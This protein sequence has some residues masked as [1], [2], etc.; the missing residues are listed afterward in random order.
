MY[1]KRKLLHFQTANCPPSRSFRQHQPV[2]RAFPQSPGDTPSTRR[3]L[4][5]HFAQCRHCAALVDS[6]HNV[7]VLIADE[8]VFTLPAGFSERLRKRLAVELSGK[9]PEGQQ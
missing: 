7:V 6:V 9:A 5:A 2:Y 1:R 8:R 4:E 3:L